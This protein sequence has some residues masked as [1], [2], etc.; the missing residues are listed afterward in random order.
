MMN[1]RKIRD[2]LRLF[3]AIC[4]SWLYIPH[5]LVFLVIGGGEKC[6]IMS[7][8]KVL[9]CQINI[10]MPMMMQLLYQ[11]HNNRYF[12]T[13][14]YHRI[15]SALSLLIDWY[16]PGDKYFTIGKTVKIGKSFW[17]AHPYATI[18]A[19]DSIGDNFRCIHCTTLGNTDK[20]RP[21]IGNNVS[22]GANVTII[23]PVHVGNNVTVAAGAV[24]VKD[25]P[26]NSVVAGVPAKII[27][28]KE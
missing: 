9:E 10:K 23:G 22:L 7:D 15:G 28:Y 8:I 17:F 26:D 27:K 18:L 3:G 25:V 24:V 11:L 12:R 1:K 21:T 2:C 13:V 19:A 5:F 4:F 16:R 14:Y 20:G 6:L